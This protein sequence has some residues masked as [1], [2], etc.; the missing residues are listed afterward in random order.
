[1]EGVWVQVLEEA[2]GGQKE[3]WML[4]IREDLKCF[5]LYPVGTRDSF[6]VF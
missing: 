4:A 1:M 3:G 2:L 6:K 5:R